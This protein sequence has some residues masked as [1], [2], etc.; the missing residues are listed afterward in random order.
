MRYIG[1]WI[2]KVQSF[3]RPNHL[4]SARFLI[5]VGQVPDG[6]QPPLLKAL[7]GNGTERHL[8]DSNS[9]DIYPISWVQGWQ[10]PGPVAWCPVIEWKSIRNCIVL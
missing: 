3:T 9:L 2:A 8:D 4:A 1:K 10:I 7:A 6:R 5:T